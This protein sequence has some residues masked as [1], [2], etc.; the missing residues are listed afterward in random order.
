MA[1]WPENRIRKRRA[2]TLSSSDP[3]WIA[4]IRGEIDRAP[5]A[6]PIKKTDRPI[7]LPQR[8]VAIAS[9]CIKLRLKK[10]TM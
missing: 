4:K 2:P 9:I 8:G 5:D 7:W 3:K 10:A 1:H 6:N